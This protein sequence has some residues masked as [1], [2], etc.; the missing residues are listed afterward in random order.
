MVHWPTFRLLFFAHWTLW[1]CLNKLISRTI[2]DNAWN[3]L[4]IFLPLKLISICTFGME[5]KPCLTSYNMKKGAALLQSFIFDHTQIKSFK[6]HKADSHNFG[7]VCSW[8]AQYYKIKH[9]LNSHIKEENGIFIQFSCSIQQAVPKS[10]KI[11]NC[12]IKMKCNYSVS[13]SFTNYNSE[14]LNKCI[15]FIFETRVAPF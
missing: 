13:R 6:L 9:A 4:L 11:L 1:K 7:I 12:L 15:F 5:I 3:F 8:I 10:T 2:K 14:K